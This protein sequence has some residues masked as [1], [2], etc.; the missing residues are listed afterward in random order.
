[1][2]FHDF[3]SFQFQPSVVPVRTLIAREKT[4]GSTKALHL[5]STSDKEPEMYDIEIMQP[6]TRDDWITGIREAV[7]AC[8]PGIIML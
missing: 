1:M 5:I 8:S 3:F 4:G 6:P 7:D 2:I